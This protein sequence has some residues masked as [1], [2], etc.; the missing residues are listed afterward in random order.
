MV[1][2]PH[3]ASHYCLVD[4]SWKDAKEDGGI[5]WSLYSKEGIQ[6]LRGSSSIH[7]TNS[8]LE[9]EAISMSMAVQ[10]MRALRANL[11]KPLESSVARRHTPLYRTF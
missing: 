4:A 8:S 3:N 2:I 11:N 7:S 9:A 1:F 10:Q 6:V 5:G